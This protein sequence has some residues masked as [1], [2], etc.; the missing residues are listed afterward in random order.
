MPRDQNGIYSLPAGYKAVSGQKVLASQHNPPLEDLA[1]SMTNSLPRTGVAPM[2]AAL[3]MG[4]NAITGLA[5]GSANTDAATFGQIGSALGTNT[6]AAPEKTTPV[7]DD[8]TPLYDSAAS[9]VLRKLKWSSIKSALKTYFDTLYDGWSCQPIGVPIPILDNL[10]GT[11]APPTNKSYRYIVLTA[12]LTDSGEYNEGIL[13]SESISGTAPLVTATAVINLAGS[14]INGQTVNLIN[15]EARFLRA[16]T[17]AG[18]VQND[19]LQDHMHSVYQAAGVG[20]GGGNRANGFT[21]KNIAFGTSAGDGVSYTALAGDSSVRTATE[22]RPK[23]IGVTYY[24]R[25][26]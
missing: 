14:P 21:S 23:N 17:S 7:D 12:G 13:T 11:A 26:K 15:T 22:T 9:N 1:A 2:T 8:Y 18:T 3:Q 10:T 19:A 24:M 4:G 20:T 25:I 5:D 16:S 6:G